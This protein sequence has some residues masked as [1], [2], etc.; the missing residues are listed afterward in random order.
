MSIAKILITYITTGA[1]L[2]VSVWVYLKLAL[3]P[4]VGALC[5]VQLDIGT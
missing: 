1:N 5:I 2:F 4:F 3:F